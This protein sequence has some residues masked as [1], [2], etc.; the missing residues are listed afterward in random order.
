MLTRLKLTLAS[1]PLQTKRAA[2]LL[3]RPGDRRNTHGQ[4]LKANMSQ[5]SSIHNSRP[6]DSDFVNIWL[7]IGSSLWEFNRLPHR[8]RYIVGG[9]FA[10]YH[11]HTQQ[12][13]RMMKPITR[14][15]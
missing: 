7:T 2:E 8:G 15:Y 6:C 11:K 3:N 14:G 4:N 13:V 10:S 12:T 9:L 5:S 1:V